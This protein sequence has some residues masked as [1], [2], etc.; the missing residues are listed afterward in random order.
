MQGWP[1]QV[2]PE[3]VPYHQ[4]QNELSVECGCLFWGLRVVVPAKLQSVVLDELH[5][6][7]PG[8]VKI[9]SLAR[10][11]VWWPGIDKQIENK[12]RSCLPCQCS[13][14]K[15]PTVLLHP[16]NWPTRPWQ[17]IHVDYAGPFQGSIFL[18]VVDSRSKWLEVIPV[19]STTTARTIV[20][21]RKLFAQFGLPEQLVTDN[22]PQFVAE[23]FEKFLKLNGIKHLRSAPYH[24]A[25][26]GEAERFVQTLTGTENH[27][28]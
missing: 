20:E 28:E 13:R 24:P 26:N 3:L 14:N 6:C 11:H 4:K 5:T 15:P 18:V 1:R 19:S 10:T 17:R 21:L 12:V 7:H 9:K 8:V 2:A 16:W 27:Q 23:E 22:G 25:T